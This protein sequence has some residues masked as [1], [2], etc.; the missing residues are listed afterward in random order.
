MNCE[1]SRVKAK[2]I[3]VNEEAKSQAAL[4]ESKKPRIRFWIISMFIVQ[5]RV[6]LKDM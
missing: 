5:E 4:S 3:E 2:L 1:R 6:E